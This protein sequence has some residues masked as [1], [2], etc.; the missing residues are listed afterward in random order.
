MTSD[1]IK[2]FVKI[3]FV[4]NEAAVNSLATFME[5]IDEDIP[6]SSTDEY[7]LDLLNRWLD[8]S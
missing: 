4:D 8:E 7:L 5:R 1:E 2:T 3:K 6:R